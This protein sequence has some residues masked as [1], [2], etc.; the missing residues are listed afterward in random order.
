MLNIFAETFRIAT[1]TDRPWL[2]DSLQR[3]PRDAARATRNRWF[4]QGRRWQAPEGDR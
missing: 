2:R 4:W 3:E 1:F